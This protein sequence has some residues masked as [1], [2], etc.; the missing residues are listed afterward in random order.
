MHG[1]APTNTNPTTSPPPPCAR[2][3]HRRHAHRP[4]VLVKAVQ[5]QAHGAR[6]GGGIA[7]LPVQR[8]AKRL[9]IAQPLERKVVAGHVHL[10]EHQEQG[11]AGL[12][13]DAAGLEESVWVGGGGAW[14]GGGYR[15]RSLAQVA[16]RGREQRSTNSR[17]RARAR[18]APLLA[19]CARLQ[20]VA[21]ECLGAGAAGG[22]HHERHH[23]G[24]GRGKGLGDDGAWVAGRQADR[25]GGAEEGGGSRAQRVSSERGREGAGAWNAHTSSETGA[26]PP[27]HARPL[28][29]MHAPA[30]PRASASHLTPTM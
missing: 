22:V 7:A 10:I 18:T 29:R 20:H 3:C 28:A 5:H 24:E 13:K 4:H 2:A 30:R 9:E 25:R 16:G 26:R 23:G 12:V 6:E 15:A 19:T 1:P 8:R 21:H 14:G 11:E 27:R 17:R